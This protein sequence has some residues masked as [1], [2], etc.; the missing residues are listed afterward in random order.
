M[1]CEAVNHFSVY[2]VYTQD[3]TK[4]FMA[5]NIDDIA[6]DSLHGCLSTFFLYQNDLY[7]LYLSHFLFG[8]YQKSKASAAISMI[9]TM[10]LKTDGN[11]LMLGDFPISSLSSLCLELSV[12]FVCRVSSAAPVMGTEN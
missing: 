7:I 8:E 10:I 4:L 6:G 9:D 1:L 11:Y 5:F 3:L 12:N 2:A